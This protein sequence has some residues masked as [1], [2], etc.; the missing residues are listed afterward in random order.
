[1]HGGGFDVRTAG[2]RDRPMRAIVFFGRWSGTVGGSGPVFEKINARAAEKM[3]TVG[4][5]MCTDKRFLRLENLKPPR[6][7]RVVKP[8]IAGLPHFPGELK[9]ACDDLGEPTGN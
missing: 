5:E 2:V 1:M 7:K 4:R 6:V 3:G 9:D 8:L